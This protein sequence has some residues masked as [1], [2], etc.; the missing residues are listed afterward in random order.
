M[1][2]S[3]IIRL[4]Q[5]LCAS[6][7]LSFV[8][9]CSKTPDPRQFSI[10]AKPLDARVEPIDEPLIL[11]GR[12]VLNLPGYFVW[13]GSVVKGDDGRF[14]MLF[15]LWESETPGGSFSRN[16][17][18]ESQIGYAVSGSASGPFE[19][20]GVV[21]RGSRFSGDSLRWD[22]YSVHNPH[23]KRFDGTYYLYYTGTSDPGVQPVGSTGY[24][25]DL[26][27][28]A[29]QSQCIGVIAFESFEDLLTG[30]FIRPSKPLLAPRTRVK[31]GK[32]LNGSPP[33]VKAKP[34][35]II[36]VN[37]SVVFDP[38]T[39]KY[40]LYFKGNLYEPNW[41]G[42]HGVA[43]G[44]SP[45]GPFEARDEFIFDIRLPDGKIASTEDPYVWYSEHYDSFFAVVKD[46]TGRLSGMKKT[47]ALLYSEDGLTWNMTNDPVFVSREV[48][49]KDGSQWTLE[50]LER[51]QLLL[52][53]KGIPETL[54]AAASLIPVGSRNDGTSINL[55]ISLQV[56]PAD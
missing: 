14:H 35:N 12:S 38:N 4:S 24:G 41:K 28:R 25:L 13:G 19:F 49:L 31:E 26:R 23:L 8:F 11:K 9:A 16:W 21:L 43:I 32:I 10:E 40:L 17:V 55:Q 44:D 54:Y 42:A 56:V 15:S 30:N 48:T 6:V 53:D 27:S 1:K 50:H 45:K 46:F 39:E 20:R 29:Q 33:G 5:L 36:T 47:L 18:L 52:D 7:L 22:A 3:A 34:D 2:N 51:P 37:P